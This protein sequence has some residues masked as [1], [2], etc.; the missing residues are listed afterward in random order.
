MPVLSI[1]SLLF[2]ICKASPPS[3]SSDY[4]FNKNAYIVT[5]FQ[6]ENSTYLPLYPG[7]SISPIQK[8]GKFSVPKL[9]ILIF[10]KVKT[11]TLSMVA[12]YNW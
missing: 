8:L 1:L 3:R 5:P 7:F 11:Y 10:R 6:P 12:S 2:L 4:V 9:N